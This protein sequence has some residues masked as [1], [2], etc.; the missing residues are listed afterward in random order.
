MNQI[1]VSVAIALIISLLIFLQGWSILR[2]AGRITDVQTKAIRR[3]IGWLTVLFATLGI[4]I[5]ILFLSTDIAIS[6]EFAVFIIQGKWARSFFDLCLLGLILC[7]ALGWELARLREGW[8]LRGIWP[9][10]LGGVVWLA[11]IWI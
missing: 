2:G 9:Y 8:G 10:L 1:N 11:S 3:L 4:T 6:P 7:I 5:N